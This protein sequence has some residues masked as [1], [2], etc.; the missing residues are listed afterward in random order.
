M[1]L[2]GFF[3]LFLSDAIKIINHRK[4]S[5]KLTTKVLKGLLR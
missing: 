4:I 2:V 1:L 3:Y 5:S